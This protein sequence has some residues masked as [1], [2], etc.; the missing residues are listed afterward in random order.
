MLGSPWDT[1]KARTDCAKTYT[2]NHV[3]IKYP[4]GALIAQYNL[5][6]LTERQSIVGLRR[7]AA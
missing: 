6:D 3:N 1:G 2:P 5:Y 7:N 4:C